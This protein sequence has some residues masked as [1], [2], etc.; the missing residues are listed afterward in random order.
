VRFLSSPSALFWLCSLRCESAAFGLASMP[1]VLLF[2]LN[3]C[4]V[5]AEVKLSDFHISIP[6]R[7]RVSCKR[8]ISPA[9]VFF[10][11]GLLSET[12]ML[13]LVVFVNP[14]ARERFDML[15]LDEDAKVRCRAS[16]C[17]QNLRNRPG[18]SDFPLLGFLSSCQSSPACAPRS[19]R[20]SSSACACRRCGSTRRRCVRAPMMASGALL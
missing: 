8:D 12:A 6:D 14:A 18:D 20:S 17:P 13:M 9:S 10:D 4:R 1:H 2:L 16:C 3:A 7:S 19:K 5:D 11:G 15:H